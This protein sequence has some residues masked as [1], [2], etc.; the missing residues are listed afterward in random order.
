MSA[1]EKEAF[2][3]ARKTMLST[4]MLT[5][6]APLYPPAACYRIMAVAIEVTHRDGM[7]AAFYAY[8][9]KHPKSVIIRPI[10][11]VGTVLCIA[12][13]VE[14]AFLRLKHG[15]LN[16]IPQSA[17]DQ[18]LGAHGYDAWNAKELEWAMTAAFWA[19]S[20]TCDYDAISILGPTFDSEFWGKYEA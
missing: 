14:G 19:S 7:E 18:L 6:L 8:M 13:K 5:V 12:A 16:D 3:K 1:T 9:L 15:V 20:P 2:G 17:W 11:I 10:D 4:E